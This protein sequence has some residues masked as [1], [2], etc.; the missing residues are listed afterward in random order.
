MGQLGRGSDDG[1]V[2]KGIG[3]K[4]LKEYE[5]V[6]WPIFQSFKK[7]LGRHKGADTKDGK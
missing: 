3:N 6:G 7:I 2:R 4:Q 1:G 5:W